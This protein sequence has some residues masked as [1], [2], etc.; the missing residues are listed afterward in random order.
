MVMTHYS[1]L[2][3]SLPENIQTSFNM[4]HPTSFLRLHP[5]WD[6]YTF[7]CAWEIPCECLLYPPFTLPSV[8]SGTIDYSCLIYR[9]S[10]VD[11]SFTSIYILVN[12]L[13]YLNTGEDKKDIST[14]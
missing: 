9:H 8:P 10:G 13:N 1:S 2:V 14:R 11:C 4:L 3:P 5:W 7:Q 12:K 6:D